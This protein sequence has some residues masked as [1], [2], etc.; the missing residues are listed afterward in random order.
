MSLNLTSTSP[1]HNLFECEPMFSLNDSF[2]QKLDLSMPSLAD[3]EGFEEQSLD[4]LFGLYQIQEPSE[5]KSS[6]VIKQQNELAR[7]DLDSSPRS[8][9]D[10]CENVGNA[11]EAVEFNDQQKVKGTGFA[12]KDLSEIHLLHFN[13]DERLNEQ[14]IEDD[15]PLLQFTNEDQQRLAGMD[16][17]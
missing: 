3:N 11:F 14:S 2:D 12:N 17:L 1:Q 9:V 10:E 16:K 4:E 5:N 8:I 15:K 13:N 7:A 6:D